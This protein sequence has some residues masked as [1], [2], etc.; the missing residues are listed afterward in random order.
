MSAL[1]DIT[2][3]V[4]LPADAKAQGKDHGDGYRLDVET[5]TAAVE[6]LGSVVPRINEGIADEQLLEIEALKAMK[7][8]KPDGNLLKL[9]SAESS[10][11]L[12]SAVQLAGAPRGDQ[13][14]LRHPKFLNSTLFALS[15]IACT[16]KTAQN[17]WKAGVVRS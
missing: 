6:L 2:A 1:R 3:L 12:A 4:G 13:K 9:I 5:A 10:P 7:L 15:R 17:A 14:G 11:T 8:K 16:E